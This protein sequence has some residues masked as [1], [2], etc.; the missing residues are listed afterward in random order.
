MIEPIIKSGEDIKEF[1]L[2]IS[3]LCMFSSDALS[4]ASMYV[5]RCLKFTFVSRTYFIKSAFH[6][7]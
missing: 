3:S 1:S 7:K 6:S 5:H 2:Q 4:H